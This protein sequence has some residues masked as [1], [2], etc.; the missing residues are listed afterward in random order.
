LWAGSGD[1]PYF[2]ATDVVLGVREKVKVDVSPGTMNQN[3]YSNTDFFRPGN[4]NDP[5]NLHRYHFWSLHPGGG[6]WLY[7]DGSVR[8]ITYAA[9]TQVIGNYMVAGSSRPVTLLEA[10]ASRDGGE[11]FS[12]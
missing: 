5:Q 3:P 10:L 8:F 4:L 11:T 6:M 7:G 9:G 2:G 12:Y 1:Y